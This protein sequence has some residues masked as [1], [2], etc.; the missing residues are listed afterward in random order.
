MARVI[1]F[2]QVVLDDF[3]L[4]VAII[5]RWESGLGGRGHTWEILLS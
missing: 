4:L 3:V 2:K 1:R 5:R